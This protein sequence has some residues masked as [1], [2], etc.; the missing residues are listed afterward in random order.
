MRKAWQ[1]DKARYERIFAAVGEIAREAR[2]AIENGQPAALGPLMNANHD[3]LCKMG[4]SSP[5]LDHLVRAA[6]GA[7]AL[8]A[9]LS[10]GGRGGN[11]IAL[12]TPET[13]EMIAGALESAGAV[14][15]I[16]TEVGGNGDA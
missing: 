4:V 12:A 10:G 13:A 3:W 2:Q 15:T 8:G 9:K 7:G 1:V 16:V 14:H 6:R 11:M 5:E